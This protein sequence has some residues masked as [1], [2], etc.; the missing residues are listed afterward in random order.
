MNES[1]NP[2]ITRAVRC[3]RRDIHGPLWIGIVALGI[4]TVLTLISG[5]SR[6]SAAILVATGCNLALMIGLFLGH[7]WAY[8][9]LLVFAAAGVAVA[10][11]K[12]AAQGLTVLI[13]NA[14]VVVPVLLST[15][16]FFPRL[17]QG[18]APRHPHIP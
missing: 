17:Q 1:Q 13:G 12:S 3:N 16:F 10:F 2:D 15:D 11:S 18:S 9:L 6:G 5:L 14:S 8:V 7:R 4:I